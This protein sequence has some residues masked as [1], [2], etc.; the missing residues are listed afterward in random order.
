[1]R[2]N[3]P[4]E[5]FEIGFAAI[6]PAED[7]RLEPAPPTGPLWFE[8]EEFE[9]PEPTIARPEPGKGPPVEFAEAERLDPERTGEDP[10]DQPPALRRRPVAISLL[11]SLCVHLLPLIVLIAGGTAPAATS[12]AIPVQLVIEYPPAPAATAASGEAVPETETTSNAAPQPGAPA[13]AAASPRVPQVAAA[14]TAASLP[15]PAPPP[16]VRRSRAAHRSRRPPPSVTA[17]ASALPPAETAY[18][19]PPPGRAA[20]S[21]M[22]GEQYF[23]YLVTLTRRHFDLLPLSLIGG[24]RGTTKVSVLVLSDGTIA[25][26]GIAQSSGYPDIDA[27][28]GRMVAAVGHFPPLPST[29]KGPS[30]ELD[31]S[32]RFPDALQR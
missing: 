6:W 4:P 16:A 3:A 27:R 5:E 25:R 12:G 21:A 13:A 18:Q 8:F 23:A 28:I 19:P 22:T 10:D 1:M 31:L 9:R 26:I 15:K 2:P 7:S 30:T 32:L 20:G 24:R 17:A 14:A 11:G 29:F